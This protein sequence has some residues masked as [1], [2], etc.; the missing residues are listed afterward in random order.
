MV[1]TDKGTLKSV[2]LLAFCILESK[3]ALVLGL[4]GVWDKKKTAQTTT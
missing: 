2:D 3:A 1:Q 4:K